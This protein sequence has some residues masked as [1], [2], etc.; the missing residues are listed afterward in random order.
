MEGG[1]FT[2]FPNQRIEHPSHAKAWTPLP[3]KLH[4]R[5]KARDRPGPE[6]PRMGSGP[7]PSRRRFP[8][9][10]HFLNATA[11]YT[12]TGRGDPKDIP[13]CGY[14][15]KQRLIKTGAYNKA[16]LV[17]AKRNPF[18][19]DAY[20]APPPKCR[21]YT[22]GESFTAGISI[23]QSLLQLKNSNYDLGLSVHKFRVNIV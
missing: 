17:P 21:M 2:K 13:M 14:S 9:S 4:P 15:L 16:H 12:G 1:R 7:A 11:K 20:G 19:R 10:A 6:T 8:R 5:D 3:G 18:P 22:S 23:G